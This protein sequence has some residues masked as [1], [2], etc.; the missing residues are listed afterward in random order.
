MK[1]FRIS[2]DIESVLSVEQLWPDGDAP[3]NPT[4]D[5]VKALI[6]K[7]GGID[8]IEDWNL[9]DDFD[10]DVTAVDDARLDAL[11]DKLKAM[12]EAG[13]KTDG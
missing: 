9:A 5:D 13:E 11:R 6:D 1:R 7:C 4:A 12:A 3:E 8:I 2:I 10:I